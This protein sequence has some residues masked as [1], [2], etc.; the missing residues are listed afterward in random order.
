[1]GDDL[2]CSNPRFGMLNGGIWSQVKPLGVAASFDCS[3][4]SVPTT[5]FERAC[6]AIGDSVSFDIECVDEHALRIFGGR[7][8]IHDLWYRRSVEYMSYPRTVRQA[9]ARHKGNRGNRRR[10]YD[11]TYID[12]VLHGVNLSQN[13]DGSFSTSWQFREDA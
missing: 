3:P 1:M 2:N 12:G 6:Y 7:Q 11:I 4:L 5:D 13:E 8:S 9:K 10:E